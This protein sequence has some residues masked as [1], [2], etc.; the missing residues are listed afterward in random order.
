MRRPFS[1]ISC[2][3]DLESSQLSA[4]NTTVTAQPTGDY[5]DSVALGNVTVLGVTG[6][7]SDVTLNGQPV[8]SGWS[9]DGTTN[10]LSISGLS[11][12]TSDGAWNS[13]WKLQWSVPGSGSGSSNASST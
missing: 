6:Q 7:V 8:T 4:S 10:I 2:E 12:L 11:G 1:N 13:D 3:T 5:K 9:W